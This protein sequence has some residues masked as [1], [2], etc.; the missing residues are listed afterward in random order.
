MSREAPAVGLYSIS[1]LA[2]ALGEEKH[3]FMSRQ[4]Y[5]NRIKFGARNKGGEFAVRGVALWNISE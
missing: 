1:T 5:V 3:R 4:K 2:K